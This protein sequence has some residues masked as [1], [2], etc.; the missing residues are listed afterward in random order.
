MTQ[1]C[2]LPEFPFVRSSALDADARGIELLGDAPVVR[3][4][5]RDGGELWVALGNEAARQVVTDPRFSRHA[6]VEPDGPKIGNA[7]PDLLISMDGKAHLAAR[8]LFSKAF[9]PR[10]VEN[11]RP[12]IE[13]LVGE[14]LD[15]VERAGPPLDLVEHFTAPLPVSVICQLLGVP[16]EDRGSFMD[17]TDRMLGDTGYTPQ[18][19]GEGIG[20]LRNY[21]RDLVAAKRAHPGDDLTTELIH[22]RAAGARLTEDQLVNNLFLMLGAGHDTTLKQLSNSLLLLLTRREEYARLCERPDLIPNAVEE[23]L[24]YLLLSPTGML[25]RVAVQDV[26]LGGQR[27][28]A[29]ET[30]AVL[31]HVANRDPAL[32]AC[33]NDLDLGRE[34]AIKHLSFGAGPHFC[35]GAP[36][37]RLELATAL[38]E[39]TRRLPGL[40]LAVPPQ[41][42]PWKEGGLQRGPLRLPVEW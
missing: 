23:L 31:H 10:M 33:P 39:L 42:V 25:I 22:V 11:M 14:L 28:R 8:R 20:N 15:Q 6:A 7:V 17:W 12:W 19:I 13:G 5:Y 34:D 26:E 36:L 35:L 2:P 18:E 38:T 37:A 21:M 41:E 24:R 9:T 3:A 16:Y 30:V 40:R 27:V 32:F 1:T 4:R 29:G